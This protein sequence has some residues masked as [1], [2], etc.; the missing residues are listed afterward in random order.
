[1]A[2]LVVTSKA[3]VTHSVPAG[4]TLTFGRATSCTVCLHPEDGGISRIAGQ[5]TQVGDVWFVT[6]RSG[7]RPLALVDRFG[8]RRVLGPGERNPVEGRIRV[9]VDGSLGSHELVLAGPE[10]AG[11]GA[12]EDGMV[13]GLPTVAGAGVVVNDAD[14]LALVAMFAGYL[15]EG[16]R[17]DPVPRPYGAA[18][19]RLG[20]ERTTLIK[21]IEYLRARLTKAGVPNLQGF[22]ALQGLAEYVLTNRIITAADLVRIGL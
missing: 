13:T 7:S 20:W 5:V 3:G 16:D 6:N 12:G 21:R 17:Y 22:T 18:A 10:P 8:L 9:L 4:G 2:D 19:K 1:V 15:L 11:D 14:R